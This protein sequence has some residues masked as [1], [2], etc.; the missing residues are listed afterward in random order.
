MKLSELPVGTVVEFDEGQYEKYEDGDWHAVTGHCADCIDDDVIKADSIVEDDVIF[1][2]SINGRPAYRSEIISM[3]YS[4]VLALAHNLAE[5]YHMI[6]L[7]G[8]TSINGLIR[9]AIEEH[10]NCGDKDDYE[11]L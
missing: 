9:D 11:K 10:K 2:H 4:V 3:P 6:G 1:T 8:E 5:L 7:S